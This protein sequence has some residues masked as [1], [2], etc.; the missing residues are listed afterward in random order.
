M[1]KLRQL[2]RSPVKTVL[3]LVLSCLSCA[4]FCLCAGQ[5]YSAIKTRD[6]LESEFTTIALPNV[7]TIS[8]RVYGAESGHFS[9]GLP[10]EMKKYM[11]E[12]VKENSGT[13]ISVENFNLTNAVSDVCAINF[14]AI[15]EYVPVSRYGPSAGNLTETILF[16]R[17]DDIGPV[18]SEY[19]EIARAVY[20]AMGFPEEQIPNYGME[21]IITGT[22][23]K[24]VALNKDYT[25]PVGRKAK[26][27]FRFSDEESF[28]EFGLKPGITC[29]VFGSSYIDDDY[30]LRKEISACS[31]GNITDLFK[32]I[33]WNNICE[34]SEE[35]ILQMKMNNPDS[36]E[37]WRYEYV[38]SPNIV[39]PLKLSE[40]E[41]I[42]RISVTAA[43]NIL[44]LS[45]KTGSKT[46]STVDGNEMTAAEY[47]TTYSPPSIRVIEGD[48]EEYL[49]G[50]E[51]GIWRKW[52]D[53]IDKESRSFPV[54]STGNFGSIA[55][56]ASGDAFIVEGRAFSKAEHSEKKPVCIISES[57]AVKNRIK[58]G[59]SIS[60]QFYNSDGNYNYG[61]RTLAVQ[62]PTSNPAAAYYS[63]VQGFCSEEKQF[64]VIGIYRQKEQWSSGTYDFT[65]NTIFVPE[66]TQEGKSYTTDWGFFSSIVLKNGSINEIEEYLSEDGMNGVLVYYD[67]GYSDIKPALDEYFKV[68]PVILAAGILTWLILTAAFVYIF[69]IH[70]KPDAIRMNSLGTEKKTITRQLFSNGFAIAL[71][72]SVAGVI[73]AL[74]LMERIVKSLMVS[75]SFESEFSP[76][77]SNPVGVLMALVELAATAVIIYISSRLVASK[78]AVE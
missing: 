13:V 73:L 65:P 45:G 10:A 22:V 44:V 42:N 59:D 70:R 15:P 30:E 54:V 63:P 78:S 19:N 26:I 16:I 18:S 48:V 28:G 56:F 25:D 37:F 49:N 40:Y 52:A 74:A 11:S 24:T 36:D 61:W 53:V 43:E 23:L 27:T 69:I 17:I 2:V 72:G 68:S 67:R 12:L 50:S 41:M 6:N 4:I 77:I 55:R 75:M 47:I 64:E 51:G 35:E 9:N 39:M 5:F 38:L 14:G 3:G 60:L 20:V 57:V 32:D 29:L 7:A 1:D 58:V 71:L 21:C 33:D 62:G 34:M 66:G 46:V 76:V 31:R 8:E